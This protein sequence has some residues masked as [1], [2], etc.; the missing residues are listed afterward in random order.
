VTSETRGPRVPTTPVASGT[1][2][3]RWIAVAL[4]P[5][6]LVGVLG[7]AS[8]GPD[9]EQRF[10]IDLSDVIPSRTSRPT[11]VATATPPVATP[12]P[13]H[14]WYTG[15]AAPI[16]STLAYV[17]DRVRLFHF[18]SGRLGDTTLAKSG[19]DVLL[20]SATGGTVCLCWTTADDGRTRTLDLVE[21][22]VAGNE[23]KRATI[24]H[25]PP[26]DPEVTSPTSI[27]ATIAAA[28]DGRYAYLARVRDSTDGWRVGIAAIDLLSGAITDSRELDAALGGS[29]SARA[30]LAWPTMSVGA[31]GR[32]ALVSAA[33]SQVGPD[34]R[35]IE[36]RSAW[37]VALDGP[38]VGPVT[39]AAALEELPLDACGFVGF[40]SSDVVAVA[41]MD[42]ETEPA[43]GLIFRRF[44]SAGRPLP[45]GPRS[46]IGDV[47]PPLINVTDGVA[48]FWHPRQHAL[49][50]ADVVGG[51]A[52]RAVITDEL[53]NPLM[54]AR[55]GP[56]P[57]PG[58]PVTWSTGLPSGHMGK[59]RIIGSPDG[60][61]LFAAGIGQ[62]GGS[63]GIWVFDALTLRLIERW[64]ASASYESLA[65]FDGGRWLLAVGRPGVADDG[66][67][68]EWETSV[69]I[70]DTSTGR[71]V[72]RFGD[73]GSDT[74]LT[75][76]PPRPLAPA[77]PSG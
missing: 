3:H 62:R 1:G 42:R 40:V 9:P 18:A 14:E 74:T 25:L 41:C 28:P 6:V 48:Y 64:P 33:A 61:L 21:I 29:A 34:G 26:N 36:R 15:P 23:R 5:I 50:A 60:R 11:A 27:E 2:R 49:V 30:T 56:R 47:W 17:G 73:F 16:G 70:H 51:D 66:R 45:D 22:G 58:S 35:T 32:H 57:E 24:T 72:V 10:A 68:A 65:M 67:P 53:A 69:T 20:R 54:V 44:D 38:T 19:R 4:V 52:R 55:R 39:R 63:S 31:D 76:P 43:T 7:V 46:S 59:S 12:L 75:F 37:I 71:P 77:P 8:A 13:R